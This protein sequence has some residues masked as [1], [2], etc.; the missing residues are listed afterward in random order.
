MAEGWWNKLAGSGWHASSAGSDPTGYVHPRAVQVMAEA[1][2]DISRHRSQHIDEFRNQPFDLVV[3]V[4]DTA[5]AACPA[6]PGD[7]QTLHWPV[8]DPA[9][10]GGDQ[11][12]QLAQFRSVRDQIRQHII[13]WLGLSGAAI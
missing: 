1:G 3:T 11:T 2:I 7:A 12:R 6:F 13:D 8:P 4:C 9:E 10:A 5:R